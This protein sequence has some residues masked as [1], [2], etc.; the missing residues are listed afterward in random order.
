[1]ALPPIV[2]GSPLSLIADTKQTDAN[3]CWA[4]NSPQTGSIVARELLAQKGLDD[5]TT[6][7]LESY[8]PALKGSKEKPPIMRYPTD[9]GGPRSEIPHVMQFK[10][11][12]RW[13]NPEFAQQAQKLKAESESTLKELEDA[14]TLIEDGNFNMVDMMSYGGLVPKSQLANGLNMILN[15]SFVDPQDPSNNKNLEELLNNPE[16]REEGRRVMERNLRNANDRVNSIGSEFGTNMWGETNFGATDITQDKTVLSNRFN[17]LVNQATPQGLQDA[18]SSIGLKQRDPQYDQMVS[19]YLPVCTRING[20][21]AFSY[22]DFDMKKAAG[23]VAALASIGSSEGFGDLVGKV[24]EL[25]KQGAV[26]YATSLAKDSAFA[27]VI[28][29]V[30]GLVLNPR[31]EKMFQQKE[32]RQFIFSWDFYPRNEA[33]VRNIKDII[34]TFRYHSHPARSSGDVSAGQLSTDPQ[35]MLRVPAE[36][37]VKFLS[38]S[39]NGSGNGFAEN[40]YIP[41]ISRCVITNIAVDYT[42]NGVFSTLQDNSPTAYTLTITMSEVAQLTRE[43]VDGGF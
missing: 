25:S 5:P 23:A 21:D 31:V 12:W 7:S 26:A 8:S 13:E 40:E 17:R 22:T 27:G 11:Y 2:K 34:D 29:A 24:G 36:F 6:N 35:I 14:Q 37:T 39:S 15:P 41:K 33:E 18:L 10:I 3:Y 9:I 30:T 32:I 20:E 38:S 19:I 16:T 43:D 1:M 4:T 42:P 28:P